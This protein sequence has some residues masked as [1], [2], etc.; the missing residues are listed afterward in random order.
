MIKV[1]DSSISPQPVASCMEIL[2]AFYKL[3]ASIFALAG[4]SMLDRRLAREL[5][6]IENLSALHDCQSWCSQAFCKDPSDTVL[7]IAAKGLAEACQVK[8]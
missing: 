7:L 5:L 3:A 2:R 8:I 1:L 4:W 6:R